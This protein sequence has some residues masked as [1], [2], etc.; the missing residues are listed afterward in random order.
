MRRG[1]PV[2]FVL[3]ALVSIE[4]TA[5]SP[6]ANGHGVILAGEVLRTGEYI[7]NGT[8]VAVMQSDG[9]FCEYFGSSASN[10]KPGAIWCTNTTGAGGR[11]S[12]GMHSTGN[13]CATTG[14]EWGQGPAL[15]CTNKVASG[16]SF[17]AM[18]NGDGNIITYTGTPQQPGQILWHHGIVYSTVAL[19]QPPGDGSIRWPDG[20]ACP[21]VCSAVLRIGT[22]VRLAAVTPTPQQRKFD[23]WTGDRCASTSPQGACDVSVAAWTPSLQS[24]GAVYTDPPVQVTVMTYARPEGAIVWPDGTTCG[25]TCSRTFPAGTSVTVTANPNPPYGFARW[26][27]GSVCTGTSPTCT[28]IAQPGVIDFNPSYVEQRRVIVTQAASGKVKGAGIDCGAAC[29][30]AAPLNSAYTLTAEPAG[31][32]FFAGWSGPCA[33]QGNPCQLTLSA[34]AAVSASFITITQGDI[35][36][37]FS[38]PN[39]FSFWLEPGDTF[40]QNMTATIASYPTELVVPSVQFMRIQL[41]VVI[42]SQ[43]VLSQEIAFP[44]YTQIAGESAL[45]FPIHGSFMVKPGDRIAVMLSPTAD[46]LGLQFADFSDPNTPSYPVPR[47]NRNGVLRFALRGKT[48]PDLTPYPPLPPPDMIHTNM[49]YGRGTYYA[50]PAGKTFK[51]TLRA[52]WGGMPTELGLRIGT[53]TSPEPYFISIYA[54]TDLL[55]S[56]LTAPAAAGSDGVTRIP[57]ANVARAVN[58]GELLTIGVQIVNHDTQVEVVP[59][60]PSMSNDSFSGSVAFYVKKVP[61]S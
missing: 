3:L 52:Y 42:N 60:L 27:A 22:T 38:K 24:V 2:L 59:S 61:G 53:P 55:C 19:Q 23:R 43:Q 50:A 28:F 40:V 14:D 47:F 29:Q 54:G 32:Y 7:T 4:A 15:W 16:S 11:F 1:V 18:L 58:V 6:S 5:Q 49:L 25:T 8:F 46:K 36:S 30:T 57:L 12:I 44:G 21:P 37:T 31:G 33:G 17:F 26:G 51:Q 45:V 48:A 35:Q 13:F 56:G 41:T 10:F 39:A 34:D 9:N 20:Q